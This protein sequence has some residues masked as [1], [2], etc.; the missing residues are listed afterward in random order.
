MVNCLD[1]LLKVVDDD[2]NFI[3][4]IEW[5]K[6]LLDD[7]SRTVIAKCLCK[8]Q[9]DV[10]EFKSAKQEKKEQPIVLAISYRLS[11]FAAPEVLPLPISLVCWLFHHP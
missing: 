6:H 8:Y 2:A 11:C 7:R 4:L 10:H 3:L 9:A 5:V 1:I